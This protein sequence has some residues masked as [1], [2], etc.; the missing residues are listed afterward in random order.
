MYRFAVTLTD[1]Q[2]VAD[3]AAFLATLEPSKEN[4]KGSGLLLE[5]GRALYEQHCVVCH[6]RH[7]EGEGS[8]FFPRLTGQH[9]KYVRR[10]LTEVKEGTRRNANATMQKVLQDFS[11]KD[12]DALAD[13]VSHLQAEA[14]EK[15]TGRAD[16]VKASPPSEPRHDP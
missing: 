1:P 6:G 14:S 9:V 8:L 7:G 10:S 16:P 2:E 5:Q 15:R 12:L 4:G 3:L 11:D 13:Y